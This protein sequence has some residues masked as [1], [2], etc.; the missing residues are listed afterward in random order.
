MNVI[1]GSV[2]GLKLDSVKN[3]DLRPTKDRIKKS[4]F[5]ILRFELKDKN[6]LDLFGGTGQ[7]GIEAFSQGAGKVVIVELD[8]NNVSLIKKNISKIRISNNITLVKEDAVKFLGNYNYNFDIIFLDPPYK[9]TDLLKN[10]LSKISKLTYL[11][12]IIA[13]E[14][15]TSLEIPI[16]SNIFSLR[17]KYKY[18]RISLSLYELKQIF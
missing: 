8:E 18:G 6:F 15:L 3:P 13:V 16:D 7:I 11:P 4:L 9:H 2:R 12:K 10:V 1:S 14:T 5:D 17:K